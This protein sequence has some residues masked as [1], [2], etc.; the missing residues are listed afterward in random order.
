MHM[1]NRRV[2]SIILAAAMVVAIVGLIHLNTEPAYAGCQYNCTIGC[3]GYTNA[4]ACT[5]YGDHACSTDCV[6]QSW[7]PGVC[8]CIPDGCGHTKP[9]CW[10][11]G[12]N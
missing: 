11:Y 7:D 6:C 4:P 8:E 12:G 3:L 9:S 5:D 2:E 1:G 10:C